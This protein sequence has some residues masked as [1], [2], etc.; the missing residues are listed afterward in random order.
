MFQPVGDKILVSPSTTQEVTKSGI[1]LPDSAKEKPQT[2]KIVAL[3]MGKYYGDE[4]V[5]FKE[6][7]LEKGATIM[8]TKYGPTEITLNDEVYYVLESNDVLGVITK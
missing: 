6:M 7:G 1:V 4:L 8:F 3:G 2:G 5:T